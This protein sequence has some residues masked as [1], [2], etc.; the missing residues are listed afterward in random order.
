MGR[1]RQE[2]KLKRE[3]SRIGSGRIDTLPKR[4]KA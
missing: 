2:K 3:E 1:D 4:D